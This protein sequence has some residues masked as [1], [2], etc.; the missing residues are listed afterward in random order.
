MT[1]ESTALALLRVGRSFAEAAESSGLP[2]AAV[3]ELWN[4]EHYDGLATGKEP[5]GAA[6]AG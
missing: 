6:K 4:K 2:V 3:M 5:R 1:Q